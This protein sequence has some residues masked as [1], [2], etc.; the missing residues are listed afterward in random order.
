V[1]LE[2]PRLGSV[3]L[4]GGALHLD[5]RDLNLDEIADGDETDQPIAARLSFSAISRSTVSA[6]DY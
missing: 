4:R 6:S 1:L 3:F 2:Q 5:F